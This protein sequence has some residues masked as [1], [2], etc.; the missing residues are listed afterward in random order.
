MN[1]RYCIAASVL[2]ACLCTGDYQSVGSSK[3]RPQKSCK[4]ASCSCNPCT[5]K[6]CSGNCCPTETK[7]EEFRIAMRQ[8]WNDH[9]TW[10]RE[11]VLAALSDAPSTDLVAQRLLRNQD[12]IGN[13]LVPLY[14][15]AAGKKLAE[16]LKEHIL[17][18]A[19]LVKAAQKNDAKTLKT[20]GTKWHKNATDISQFLSKANPNIKFAHM[21]AMM[22]E[23][24]RL[25]TGIV[26]SHLQKKWGDDIRLYD[27]Y[28]NQLNKMA[29]E[30]AHALIKA[31]PV[32]QSTQRLNSHS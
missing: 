22:F 2:I 20:A 5:C 24:L 3:N 6:N 15:L 4:V 9:G 21:Q 25:L 23:H 13:A 12:D 26:T 7:K 8:L 29:D 14:G 17:I 16:L 11:Y 1:L 30:L 31:F 28:R 27:T 10:T 32:S 18:D 19:D